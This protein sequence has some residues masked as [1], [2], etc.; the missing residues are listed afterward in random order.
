MRA[1]FVLNMT[2]VL[3]GNGSAGIT[4]EEKKGLKEKLPGKMIPESTDRTYSRH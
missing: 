2:D 3:A 1:E 4:E